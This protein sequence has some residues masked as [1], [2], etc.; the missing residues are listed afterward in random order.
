M[1]VYILEQTIINEV[2]DETVRFNEVYE[3]KEDAINYL[4]SIGFYLNKDEC[5]YENKDM[6]FMYYRIIDRK[7]I[8]RS[9]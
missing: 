4:E 3:H 9:V 7:I 2:G 1:E 8:N 5:G 6:S